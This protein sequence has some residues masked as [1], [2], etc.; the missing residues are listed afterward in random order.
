VVFGPVANDTAGAQ[1]TMLEVSK[2]PCVPSFTDETTKMESD[3][4]QVKLAKCGYDLR[5]VVRRAP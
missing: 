3:S 2:L 1:V 5:V 4:S